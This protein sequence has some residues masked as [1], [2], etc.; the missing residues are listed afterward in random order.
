[1]YLSD[2]ANIEYVCDITGLA[3]DELECIVGR[4]AK[5]SHRAGKLRGEVLIEGDSIIIRHHFTKKVLWTN[6]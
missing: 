6:S 4:F 3:L 5:H 2:E 1:M